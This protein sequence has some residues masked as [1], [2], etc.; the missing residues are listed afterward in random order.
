[1]IAL[2]SLGNPRGLPAKAVPSAAISRSHIKLNGCR[3]LVS[4]VENFALEGQDGEW[5]VD[6]GDGVCDNKAL[7]T[8]PSGNVVAIVVD[9]FW[10]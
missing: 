5:K 6:F 3:W 1:M 10:R 7:V 2:P 8:E 9:G 4:G